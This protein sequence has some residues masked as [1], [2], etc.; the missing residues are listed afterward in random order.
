[1]E[2]TPS[3]P[4]LLKAEELADLLGLPL[5]RVYEL[6]REKRIPRVRI[7]RSLRFDPNAV[8][9][10]LNAGGTLPPGDVR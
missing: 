9:D 2:K 4:R 1:M 7:G 3:L 5:W 8:S 10:W 6:A